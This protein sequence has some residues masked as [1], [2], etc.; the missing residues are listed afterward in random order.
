MG[1]KPKGKKA[2]KRAEEKKLRAEHLLQLGPPP[3]P[4]E[5]EV[6]TNCSC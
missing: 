5:E 3:R 6:R 4:L 1:K 2:E